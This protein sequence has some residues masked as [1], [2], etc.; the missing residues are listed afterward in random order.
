MQAMQQLRSDRWLHTA[1][2]RTWAWILD[3]PMPEPLLGQ[4]CDRLRP[5]RI[6][7]QLNAVLRRHGLAGCTMVSW[8]WDQRQDRVEGWLWQR[9][10]LQRFCWWRCSDRLAIWDQLRCTS[11]AALHVLG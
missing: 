2:L 5:A 1:L 8:R 9:G 4:Q 11:A 7:H 6:S 10:L 3:E